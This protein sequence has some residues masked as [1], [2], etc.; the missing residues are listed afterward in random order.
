MLRRC[1]HHSGLGIILA[2]IGATV[3][4][5]FMLPI[6]FLAVC[7]AALLVAVGLLFLKKF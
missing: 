1:F 6:W 5:A 3:L 2:V 7:E 4:A